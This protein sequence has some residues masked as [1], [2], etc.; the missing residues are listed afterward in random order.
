MS[1]SRERKKRQEFI[2]GGGTDPKAAREAERKAKER[3]SNI[4]YGTIGAVFVLVTA[5]LV[6]Y[7]SG[8]LQRSATAVT[9]DGENYTAADYS[10]Y[11]NAM[12]RVRWENNS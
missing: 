9:I 11:Y 12:G 2:A 3:K 5:F 4:L 10:Y 8:I 1:A 6:I 7:N